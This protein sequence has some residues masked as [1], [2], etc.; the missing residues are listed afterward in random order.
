MGAE[1]DGENILLL[2]GLQLGAL[3]RLRD[4]RQLLAQRLEAIAHADVGDVG[5]ADVVPL[6]TLL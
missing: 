5:A 4:E 2:D 1:G 6:R 3:H